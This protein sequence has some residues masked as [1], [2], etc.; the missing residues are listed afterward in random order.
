MN[1]S[2][3]NG[4]RLVIWMTALLAMPL[5]AGGESPYELLYAGDYQVQLS[6]PSARL[7][8]R[9]GPGLAEPV[10][11]QYRQGERVKALRSVEGAQW[12]LETSEHCF[13]RASSAYLVWL[14]QGEDP[15]TMCDPRSEP[16]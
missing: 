4:W 16:C 6:D 9:R 3:N 2:T 7:N 12:W 8:C 13:V 1:R 14:G 10:L 11:T 5:S 15:S